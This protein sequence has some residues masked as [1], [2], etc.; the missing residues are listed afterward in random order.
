VTAAAAL[1]T[2]PTCNGT[3]RYDMPVTTHGIGGVTHT[4]TPMRCHT[5]DGQGTLTAQRVRALAR[6]KKRADAFW[7]RCAVPCEYPT[8]HMKRNGCIDWVECTAC[9]KCMQVG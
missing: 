5:C 8:V 6:E 4:V 7:C 9:R 1:Q 2:C 3:G